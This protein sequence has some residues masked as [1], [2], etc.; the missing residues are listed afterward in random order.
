MRQCDQKFS[1]EYNFKSKWQ[2]TNTVQTYFNFTSNMLISR[3][4]LS[5]N[6]PG[7]IEDTGQVRGKNTE[8]DTSVSV[9]PVS[10]T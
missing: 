1:P 2:L 5:N 4:I 3:M 9:D 8:R 10:L 7:D 6:I